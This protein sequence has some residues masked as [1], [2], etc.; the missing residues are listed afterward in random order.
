MKFT[1]TSKIVSRIIMLVSFAAVIVSCSGSASQT[2]DEAPADT[3]PKKEPIIRYGLPIED[4][5]VIYDTLHRRET[6]SDVLLPHRITPKQIHLMTQCPDTVFN[7]RKVRPGQTFAV[8]CDKD[9][10]STPHYFVFEENIKYYVVFDLQNNCSAI[11]YSNPSEWHM[12][13]AAGKVKS[14]L[15]VAMQDAGVSAGVVVEMSKIFEWSVD[16]FGIQKGDEFRIIY[17][18]EYVSGKPLNN[19]RIHAASFRASDSI[20]Y[21]IPFEQDNERLYYN[22]DGNSLEGAFLKAP[23]DFYRISSKFTNS[24]YH[25]VL[26]IYR[27][28]HGVDY[29]APAGTPVY[30]IG[31]G[32]VIEKGYQPRG[33]GNY[34][35]IKHHNT[36]YVTTYMHLSKFAKGLKKGDHVKQ[37]QVIGYVGSTGVSTGPHLDFRVHENG[38][39]INPLTIK[40]QPKQPIS[41]ANKP[42]FD[43][44]AD[45]L[46]KRLAAIPES[47]VQASA[48]SIVVDT[49][50]F[51]E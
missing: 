14:S 8:L 18:R 2:T 5:N 41:K 22:I 50:A 19:Y 25:P 16:F 34:V 37:K 17:E 21:A 38:K 3:L 11:R 36:A 15:W 32:K 47:V 40:S 24:R 13:E 4:F 9:T 29:A 44:L 45:S 31:S 39:P 48:D 33:G 30:A 1:A 27:P 51:V 28:H 12:G 42:T 49:V 46:V 10:A 6:L 35:K 7:A 20:F 43:I 23:L 26:K